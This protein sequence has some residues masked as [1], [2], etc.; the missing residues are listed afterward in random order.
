[1][2]SLIAA[3]EALRLALAPESLACFAGLGQADDGVAQ[4]GIDCHRS[5]VAQGTLSLTAERF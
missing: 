1:V 3:V 5:R 2:T 4:A